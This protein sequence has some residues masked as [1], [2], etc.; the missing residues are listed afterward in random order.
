MGQSSKF[1]FKNPTTVAQLIQVIESEFETVVQNE[2]NNRSAGYLYFDVYG[3]KNHLFFYN[4]SVDGDTDSIIATVSERYTNILKR[5]G[6]Y[7][8]G[9]LT[10]N[11]IWDEEPIF[12][13]QTKNNEL[14]PERELYNFVHS[15]M[16]YKCATTC[17]DFLK[18]NKET[19]IKLINSI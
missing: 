7:L 18:N 14:T 6:S 13:P 10:I 9:F 19:V 8:E 5:I 1:K 15:K 3:I 16:D 12:I 2:I 17:L 11:D 4:G